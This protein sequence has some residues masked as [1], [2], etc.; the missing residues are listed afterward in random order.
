M[1]KAGKNNEEE[2]SDSFDIHKWRA[3]KRKLQEENE[4]PPKR[5]VPIE[6][7]KKTVKP[8]EDAVMDKL[9][10]SILRESDKFPD[11]VDESSP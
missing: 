3:T 7:G 6:D 5:V 9:I 11:E 1:D 4:L 2:D 10:K 8:K